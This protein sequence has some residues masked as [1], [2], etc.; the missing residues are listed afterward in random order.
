MAQYPQQTAFDFPTKKSLALL[1]G[2]E[3]Y[4]HATQEFLGRFSEDRRY[5]RKPARIKPLVLQEWFSMF[6]NTPDG[7]LI[8]VGVA[9]NGEMEGCSCLSQNQLNEWRCLDGSRNLKEGMAVRLA[10]FS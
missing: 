5:E 4:A 9:D 10:R 6:A 7:G 3:I 8:A 2:D 1:G